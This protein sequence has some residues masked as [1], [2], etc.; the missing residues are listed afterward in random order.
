VLYMIPQLCYWLS[1][2]KKGKTSWERYLLVD[3]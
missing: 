1:A 2:Y 3:P